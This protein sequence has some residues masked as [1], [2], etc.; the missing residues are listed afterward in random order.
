M[1]TAFYIPPSTTT[2]ALVGDVTGTTS[3][4]YISDST[5]TGKLLTGL[6][7][8]SANGT[9]AATDSLST[10]ISKLAYNG[11][12]MQA[13]TLD[14]LGATLSIAGSNA[15]TIVNIGSGST[16]Q[17]VNI[18][19]SGIGAT[20][21]TLGGTNDSCVVGNSLTVT[22]TTNQTGLLYFNTGLIT[23]K[24]ALYDQ[25]PGDATRHDFSGFGIAA[26]TLRYHVDTTAAS[27]V[28]YAGNVGG[29]SSTTLMTVGG[30]GVVSIPGSLTL[31]GTS[32]A[33]STYESYD[34]TTTFT[35]TAVTTPAMSFRITKVGRLV[36]IT[37]LSAYTNTTGTTTYGG[38]F[39]S[40]TA[41]P[42]R[43][44]PTATV[45]DTCQVINNSV[46][47]L[48]IVS[49]SPSTGQITITGNV[50]QGTFTG[51]GNT[52]FYGFSTSYSVA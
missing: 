31:G 41:M 39:L 19:N 9:V 8:A 11:Q 49:P 47:Q 34:Y 4:T 14:G 26:G 40:N 51:V 43:F 27:H 16:V 37:S 25:T 20:A 33:L 28:F 23:K 50:A 7:T 42:S 15:T 22:G 36:T 18:G 38:Y 13:Y 21:I 24:L 30:T 29:A 46:T 48:G 17:Q 35:N 44:W 3:K 1:A 2:S 10:A 12:Y 5:V 32:T 6:V 45:Y 52:G